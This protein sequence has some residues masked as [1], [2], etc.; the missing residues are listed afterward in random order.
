MSPLLT[1]CTDTNMKGVIC[2][3]RVSWEKVVP[4]QSSTL[5]DGLFDGR[6]VPYWRG[7]C[8][9]C[10]LSTRATTLEG[11]RL[12]ERAGASRG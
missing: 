11:E 10:S 5:A 12:D 7:K 9:K 8:D 3:G 4:A 1:G 2:K 6:R